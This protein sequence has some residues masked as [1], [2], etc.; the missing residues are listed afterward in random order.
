ML[1]ARNQFA[2]TVKSVKLGNVMAEVVITVGTIEIV[3]AITRTPRKPS[4]SG[5]AIRSRR[6]SSPR[7]LS[8]TSES[9]LALSPR[10][11]TH[12]P[13]RLRSRRDRLRQRRVWRL[14]GQILL[15]SEE[16][17]ERSAL[18][19]DVIAHG[20]TQHR[21]S[22][23]QRVQNR[24]LCDRTFDREHHVAVDFRK[25]SQMERKDDSNHGSVCAST[26]TTAGR[27]RTMGAQLS[28]LSADAYT[29]PPVVPK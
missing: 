9:R 13:K 20:A 5:P 15:A 16:S 29:W 7:R 4:A 24:A 14:M 2:G 8:S 25:R 10:N 12:D 23:L 11:R 1:S 28:P 17:H 21:I 6:S 22:G 26:D 18:V 27:S 3:S 19:G